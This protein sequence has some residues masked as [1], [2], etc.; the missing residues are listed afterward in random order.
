M[1]YISDE[2]LNKYIDGE[3][4]PE[5]INSINKLLLTDSDLKKRLSSLNK[6]NTEL[7]KIGVDEVSVAFTQRV[8]QRISK[9]YRVPKEQKLFITSIIS[10]FS[11]VCVSILGYIVIN[12]A[13][14]VSETVSS[15]AEK[16]VSNYS[17][18]LIQ[19]LVSTFSGL[20]ISVFGS[21]LSIVLL[22][23]GYFFFEMSKQSKT[24]LSN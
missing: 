14:E 10:F 24:K 7:K 5:E 21:I 23:S 8:M 3:L 2:I 16:T 15:G 12:I 13:G 19:S 22:V 1:K 18:S 6:V 11:V 20:N 9:K 4:N 17:Q